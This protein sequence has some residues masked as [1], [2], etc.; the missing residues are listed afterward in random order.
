M[1]AGKPSLDDLRREIDD[2]DA[3]LH[4]LLMR[5]TELVQR[6]GAAKGDSAS[7]VWAITD[8]L[9]D[10]PGRYSGRPTSASPGSTP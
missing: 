9:V 1:D 4:D 5:R 8:Q 2:I 3:A 10:D 7:Y 6:I